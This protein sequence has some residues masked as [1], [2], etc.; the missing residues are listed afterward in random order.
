MNER[1]FLTPR[2]YFSKIGLD[3]FQALGDNHYMGLSEI[4]KGVGLG[5][6]RLGMGVGLGLLSVA[7]AMVAAALISNR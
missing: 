4:G 3:G 7:V 5:L 2:K 6:C 1:Y